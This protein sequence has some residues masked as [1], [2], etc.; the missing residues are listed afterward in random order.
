MSKTSPERA[1]I[2]KTSRARAF[3]TFCIVTHLASSLTGCPGAQPPRG[4]GPDVATLFSANVEKETLDQGLVPP[5]GVAAPGQTGAKDAHN[6]QSV[7]RTDADCGYDPTTGRCGADPR[8][9]K[10]PPLEDQGLICYCDDAARTCALLRVEPVPCE[11]EAACAIALD[12]RPHPVRATRE[13]P[14]EKPKL[15]LPPKPGTPH[16]TRYDTTCER[17]NICTMHVRDCKA[18]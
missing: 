5:T 17:T 2:S 9:N 13:R 6:E 8:L 4:P 12:P 15:C 3:A 18:P 11:G 7:C 16:E 10:Q 1:S 14:Y